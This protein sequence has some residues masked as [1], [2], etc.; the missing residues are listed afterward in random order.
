MA[1]LLIAVAGNLLAR[2][3]H[4][5]SEAPT[6]QAGLDS[7]LDGDTVLVASETY[8]E[9]LI[10]PP[11]S[12]VLRGDVIPDTGDYPRPVIDPWSIPGADVGLV[13]PAGSHPILEDLLFRH[14]NGI[15][16][17]AGDPILRRVVMDAMTTGFADSS[18]SPTRIEVESCHFVNSTG[19]GYGIMTW[20]S[21]VIATDCEFRLNYYDT[22]GAWGWSGSSFLRCR[23]AGAADFLLLVSGDSITVSECEF[24]PSAISSNAL[25]IVFPAGVTVENNAFTDCSGGNP[26]QGITPP[27]TVQF[28][29]NVFQNCYGTIATVWTGSQNGQ[30]E[31]DGNLFVNCTGGAAN[32]LFLEGDGPMWVS[33]NRFFHL[34][35]PGIAAIQ[36]EDSVA[37]STTQLRDN[38]FYDTGLAMR[39]R[40]GSV[41]AR[42]NWWGDSTGP[43][44]ATQNPNGQGDTIVGNVDFFPWYPDT[45]FL[46]NVPGIDKPL[47]KQFS[48]E[49]YPNPFNGM[50]RLRLTPQE[51]E[52][53]QVDLFDL[54]G[55]K[56]KELWSGPLA[57]Q[58]DIDF[59]AS[60]LAS[61]IYFAR[62]SNPIYNRP[63]ATAKLVL[64][65]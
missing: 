41:D 14:R 15:R 22:N 62:V 13:L 38:L 42:W 10:A 33:N 26:V 63:L 65:K 19:G 46:L 44:H 52:M 58:K 4:V 28:R 39:S 30:L 1:L 18:A 21:A 61:G 2:T 56:V 54:L 36:F 53:V 48:V 31:I 32:A 23:F 49:A 45:S 25:S 37:D 7:L 17:W 60:S 20:H 5:P 24:G 55:R 8:H 57:F 50:V 9:S 11:L 40:M 16:S 29:N 27:F 35:N 6:I 43:Y 59:D 3:I 34:N 51:I 64:L 12:F 47:P